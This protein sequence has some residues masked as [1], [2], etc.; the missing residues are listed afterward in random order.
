MR[1]GIPVTGGRLSPHFGHCEQFALIDVDE[2]KKE[3]LK[4]E[5][6]PSP[7]HQPGMLPGW[8][9]EQGASI[10]IAGGMGGRAVDIFR[11]NH[12]EVVMGA[13]S[14]DTAKVALDYIKETLTSWKW[15]FPTNPGSANQ[16]EEII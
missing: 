13:P 4:V 10:V 15:P 2:A 12:I 7:P 5:L 8:L 3:I 1:I 9:A 6:L 14:E 11:Q 16:Q